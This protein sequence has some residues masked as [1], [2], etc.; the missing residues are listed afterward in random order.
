MSRP[1]EHPDP[2]RAYELGIKHA[3]LLRHLWTHPQFFFQEPPT[4][5]ICKVDFNRTSRGVY[6]IT[7]FVENTYVKYVMPFLP[8]GATRK[9][10]EL[11]NPWAYKD[12]DYKWEWSWDASTSTL[13]DAD[14]NQIAFPRL[15]DDDGR[16]GAADIF[17]RG[18]MIK[19]IILEN[20][21]DPKA[22]ALL[23]GQSIDFGEEAKAVARSLDG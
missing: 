5:E 17:T 1:I 12:P 13:K 15:S 23:G 14:G 8:Q 4:P 7:E 11:G 2:A 22:T 16:E 18:F 10:K 20:D 19:K 9:C 21:S 6:F 3:T